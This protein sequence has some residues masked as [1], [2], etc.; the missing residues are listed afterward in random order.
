MF[1]KLIEATVARMQERGGKKLG[2]VRDEGL[3]QPKMIRKLDFILSAI[4]KN[5]RVLGKE[6]IG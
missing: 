1:K 3:A 6:E 5:W 2:G 4:D